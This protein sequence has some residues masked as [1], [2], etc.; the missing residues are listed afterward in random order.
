MG[1][2]KSTPWIVGAALVSIVILA[3]SWLLAISPSM[4]AADESRNQAALQQDKNVVLKRQIAT[5]AEQFTHLEEYK[6]SLAAIRAQIPQQSDLT[7]VNTELQGLAASAGATLTTI[8]VSTPISFSPAGAPA[9]AAAPATG[10]DPT[11]TAT[12][13]PAATPATA[14]V[15]A[16]VYAIPIT[17]VLVGTYDAA[18]AFLSSFQTGAT[19]IYLATSIEATSQEASGASNGRPPLSKGDLELSITA[20]AYV[21]L[22][23]APAV[24]TDPS[25]ATVLP[26]PSGQRNPFVSVS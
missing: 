6:T 9:A 14:T 2:T 4:A 22:G 26:A 24:A 1:A 11:G 7:A 25:A 3:M 5:L 8:T 19:R 17:I 18:T 16:G 21:M 20:Y 12:A 23:S 13:A 10:S 15:P